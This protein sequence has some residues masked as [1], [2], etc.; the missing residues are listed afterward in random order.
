M[1]NIYKRRLL[2]LFGCIPVRV[3]FVYLAKTLTKRYINFL[4]IVL[5][6][7]MIGFLQL[8]IT[9]SRRTG[10]ETFGSP[11][12][13][14]KLRIVHFSMYLIFI[15]LAIQNNECA[16]VPLLLDVIIGF[17]AFVIYHA[18]ILSRAQL[19]K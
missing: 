16:Y 2:F 11:I 7:P 14:H 3:L 19:Y 5:S 12:W 18:C 1:E 10:P 17:V 15:L 4:A 13:W 8:Y 6:I 9:N